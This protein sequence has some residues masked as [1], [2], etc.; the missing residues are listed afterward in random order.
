MNLPFVHCSNQVLQ[1]IEK[2]DFLQISTDVQLHKVGAVLKLIERP[3]KSRRQNTRLTDHCKGIHNTELQQSNNN[4][5]DR[6]KKSYS[7]HNEKKKET[8][9]ERGPKTSETTWARPATDAR[10][11]LMQLSLP[12]GT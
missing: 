2:G 3:G 7:Y 11:V 12:L 8:K 10:L 5:P 6:L 1:V 9:E 4:V